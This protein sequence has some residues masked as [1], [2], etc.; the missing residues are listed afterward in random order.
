MGRRNR[1]YHSLIVNGIAVHNCQELRC[2]DSAKYDAAKALR[3]QMTNA[4]ALSATPIYNHGGEAFNIMECIAPGI[5]GERDEFKQEWCV[6]AGESNASKWII[7]DPHALGSYLRAEHVMIRR[8]RLE[9]GRELPACSRFTQE[10]DADESLGASES[11][12]ATE[13]ARLILN[14]D[15]RSTKWDAMQAAGEFEALVRRAT[16]LAKAKSVAAFVKL[17]LEQGEPVLLAGWHHA[18]YDI[19]REELK[20]HRPVFYTGKERHPRAPRSRTTTSSTTAS[21]SVRPAGYTEDDR[22]CIP[23]PFYH[24]FGMVLGN[25]GCATH[26]A[27]DGHPGAT[28]EPLATPRSDPGRALHRPLRR[29]DDVHRRAEPPALRRVRPVQPAHGHHGRCAVSHRGDARSSTEMGTDERDHRLRTDRGVADHHADGTPTDSLEHRVGTVG[30]VHPAWRSKIVGPEPRTTVPTRR[31]GRADARA[32]TAHEGLLQQAGE[33]AAA[34]DARRLAAHPATWRRWTP[35][36][37]TA[38][39]AASRT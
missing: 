6:P 27:G 13:L 38:S 16:G 26:G 39:P 1:G 24:C 28:F 4:M 19:W 33:T 5:L 30:R 3:Q 37:T 31:A 7:K 14:H 17:L 12:G 25:L 9:V 2:N 36:A 29:A 11:K 10:V 35:T 23:V 15:K 34:I 21:S 22:V 20:D 18:V 8:T 32:A